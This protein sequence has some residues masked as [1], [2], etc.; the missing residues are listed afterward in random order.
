MRPLLALLLLVGFAPAAPVPKAIK[1]KDDASL[2]VGRWKPSDGTKQWYEFQ[3]DG[4]LKTWDEPNEQ[5]AVPYKW[6]IDVTAI[7]KRM[8][9][10]NGKTGKV[11][12]EAVYELDGD[13]LRMNYASAPAVPKA[14]GK[15]NGAFNGQVRDTSGK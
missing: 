1:K 15:G 5:S 10:A 13:D 9:W 6:T 12:F 2:L 4:T 3:D 7:P 8:T 14:V 11:E